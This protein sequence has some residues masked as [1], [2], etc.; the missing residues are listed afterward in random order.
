MGG[1]L[2]VLLATMSAL[3]LL[4][5]QLRYFKIRNFKPQAIFCGH[6][7]RIASDL[8]GIPEDRFSHDEA[9][10]AVVGYRVCSNLYKGKAVQLQ[11]CLLKSIP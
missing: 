6:S 10:T 2:K 8:V 7:A 3:S 4:I 11:V 9:P 1:F 5:V